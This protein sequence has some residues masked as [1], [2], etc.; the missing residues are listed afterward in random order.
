MSVR[1]AIVLNGSRNR[2]GIGRRRSYRQLTIPAQPS[3][4]N[5]TVAANV[6][7]RAALSRRQH[8]RARQ[9]FAAAAP[10]GAGTSVGGRTPGS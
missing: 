8:E 2:L 5:N 10:I 4:N 9:G 3:A 1:A 7:N 6:I